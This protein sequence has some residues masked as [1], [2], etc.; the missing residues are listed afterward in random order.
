[1][2]GPIVGGNGSEVVEVELIEVNKQFSQIAIQ[3]LIDLLE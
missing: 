1:M 3:I 2:R